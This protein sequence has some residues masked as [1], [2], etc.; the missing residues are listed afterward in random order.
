MQA[1][2]QVI[3]NTHKSSML[4]LFQIYINSDVVINQSNGLLESKAR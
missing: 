1:R 3:K 4:Y 2:M